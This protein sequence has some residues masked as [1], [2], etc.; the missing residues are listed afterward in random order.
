M[1]DRAQLR[2]GETVA[3]LGASGGVG[4]ALIQVAKILGARV[5]ACAST[6]EKLATCA[7]LGADELVNY[8]EVDLKVKLKELTGGKGVDVMCDPVGGKFSEIALRSTAWK[9]RFMVLGFTS[10]AIAQMPLNLP[11]LKGCSIIGVFWSTFTRREPEQ[12][13]RN[14]EELLGYF[15]T[16]DLRPYISKT[17]TFKEAKQALKD[18]AE[19]RASGKISVLLVD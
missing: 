9:G 8:S 2:A 7:Q 13:R 14:I 19:R 6:K 15:E 10:G 1:K 12:N 16:H 11:L 3:I 17:Y 18:V 5:I 4:S